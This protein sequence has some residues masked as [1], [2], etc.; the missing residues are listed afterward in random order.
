MDKQASELDQNRWYAAELLA[1]VL[2]LP[3][4]GVEE[5]KKRLIGEDAVDAL[6]K[7]LSVRGVPLAPPNPSMTS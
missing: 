2:G 7:V 6:L 1:F 3:I 5:A 4:D